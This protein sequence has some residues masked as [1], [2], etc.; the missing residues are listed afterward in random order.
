LFTALL[1][2]RANTLH[3]RV[4]PDSGDLRIRTIRGR[5]CYRWS[6]C[7]D[8]WPAILKQAEL[9]LRLVS[10]RPHPYHWTRRSDQRH[11]HCITASHPQ[12]LRA[13]RKSDPL[14][15][16]RVQPLPFRFWASSQHAG[17][18]ERE[19]ERGH[20]S[21]HQLAPQLQS[22][23]LSTEGR[24]GGMIPA[25]RTNGQ[26]GPA[27]GGSRSSPGIDRLMSDGE[28]PWG[29]SAISSCYL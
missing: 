27:V 5:G 12:L 26:I 20:Y 8:A 3:R 16:A 10:G 22:T 24:R 29:F 1:G 15:A 21:R 7:L 2:A 28:E 6:V 9:S 13:S 19:R 14:L 25:L 17:L 11:L 4:V 18:E 23:K